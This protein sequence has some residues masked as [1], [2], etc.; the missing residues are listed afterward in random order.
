MART[1]TRG[2]VALG[3]TTL[4][5]LALS[6]G[7]ASAAP[8]A[9]DRTFDHDGWI[10][11]DSGGDETANGMVVQPDGKIVVV[12][13]TTVG[14]NAAVYRLNVDGSLDRS[15]DGDGAVGLDSGGFET[16]TAVALQSDG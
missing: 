15:F 3:A 4:A 14:G 12:G 11:I 8:A 10:T 5:L 1:T 9:L 2:R 7:A 13:G 6:A 16:A